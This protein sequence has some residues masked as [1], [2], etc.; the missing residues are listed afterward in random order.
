[1]FLFPINNMKAITEVGG[2]ICPVSPSFYSNPSNIEELATTV[3]DRV[4]DL[5]GLNQ[6]GYR[7]NDD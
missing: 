7:W 1:M 5:A 3:V 4:I 2:I 6:G